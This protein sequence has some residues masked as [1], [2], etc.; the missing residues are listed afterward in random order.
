MTTGEFTEIY[1]NLKNSLK[2]TSYDHLL[3][4]LRRLVPIWILRQAYCLNIYPKICHK[5]I[6]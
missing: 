5:I 2:T 3:G 6:L 4:V 1:N